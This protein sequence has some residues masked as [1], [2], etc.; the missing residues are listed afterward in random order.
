MVRRI[1]VCV[2]ALSLL[3]IQCGTVLQVASSCDSIQIRSKEM[4][5]NEAETYRQ[6]ALSERNK[7]EAFWGATWKESNPDSRRQFL[8]NLDGVSP[9][10]PGKPRVHADAPRPSKR[11]DRGIVT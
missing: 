11:R 2:G 8:P 9:V 1:E 6:Y 4:T 3:D 5:G 7:V 10:F